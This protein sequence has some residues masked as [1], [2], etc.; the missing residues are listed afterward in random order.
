MS[1][2]EL[3]P[4]GIPTPSP[5]LL[6]GANVDDKPNFMT[7]SMSCNVN[8]EPAMVCIAMQDFKYTNKGIR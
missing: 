3:G 1:K 6:I 8:W 5:V 7:L 4:R 2:V